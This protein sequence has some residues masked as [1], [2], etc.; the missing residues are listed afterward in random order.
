MRA[1]Q[2]MAENKASKGKPMTKTAV[3]KGWAAT[4]EWEP[5]QVNPVPD[6]WGAWIKQKLGDDG[7]GT[8]ALLDLVKFEVVKKPATRAGWKD[9]PFKPGEKMQ[10]KAKPASTT[11]K[12]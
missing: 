3:A 9:T 8:F 7:P 4:T 10:V 2:A 6:A 1:R 11:V 5:K 12:A